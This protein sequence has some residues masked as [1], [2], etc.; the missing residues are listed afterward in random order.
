MQS[1]L[2][3]TV[4][5]LG[6]GDHLCG[7]YETDDEH[8]ELL[9]ALLRAGLARGDRIV[10]IAEPAV[11]EA[12]GGP[13]RAAAAAAG[14][15]RASVVLVTPREACLSHGVFTREA[16]T[17]FLARETARARGEGHAGLCAVVDM[18][19]ALGPVPEADRLMELEARLTEHLAGSAC[20]LACQYDRR[21]FPPPLL[22]H[23]L[24]THP[25]AA[26]GARVYDNLYFVPPAEYLGGDPQGAVVRRCLRGLEEVASARREG[27]G[28]HEQLLGR[29]IELTA[30]NRELEA[31]CD[32]V[33]HD[34]HAPLHSLDGFSRALLEDYG[35]R[36]DVRARDYLGRVR[37]A[38]ARMSE[39]IDGLRALSRHSGGPM[40]LADVDLS[41]LA[42]VIVADLRAGEPART[43]EA[44]I[45][46]GL[47]ARGDAGLLRVALGNLLENAWK[48]TGRREAA[49][50]EVGARTRGGQTAFFVRDD[51]VGFD[52]PRATKLF[53]AFQRLPGAVDFPGTGVGLAT[54]QRIV[55]RHGGRVWAEAAPGQ[56]ATFWFTLDPDAVGPLEAR[57]AEP[58][59]E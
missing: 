19:W 18:S 38:S 39:L 37:S 31:F 13:L 29:A 16:L 6:P 48:F 2:P 26:V 14:R 23:A 46:P 57:S 44:V 10:F 50:V 20:L 24:A 45:Q 55:H 22:L 42:A 34:L 8:R 28:R 11:V 4:A 52:A 54:V 7:L 40:A 1:A 9:G 56:G 25:R 49:R 58:R 33:S 15:G 53:G 3:L 30:W 17:A 5:D 12:M 36:L 27:R 32:A 43:V 47:R 59:D 21:R 35:A 41:A 51:G